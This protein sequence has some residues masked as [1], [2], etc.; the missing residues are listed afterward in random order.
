MRG[1]TKART[2][3]AYIAQAGESR[4][5]DLRRLHRII[6]EEAPRLKPTMEFGMLG[7]GRFRYRY[8]SGREG[9][10]MK[11]GVANNN[12]QGMITIWGSAFWPS[13]WTSKVQ[14]SPALRL[15]CTRVG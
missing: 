15:R 8:A 11:I 4:R 5:P 7:Y 12:L 6:R 1:L 2:P 10:W 9:D 14:V 3:T 13:T